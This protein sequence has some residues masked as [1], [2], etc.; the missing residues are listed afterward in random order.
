VGWQGYSSYK[1]WRT[2]QMNIPK[3]NFKSGLYF[4]VLAIIAIIVINI[5]TISIPFLIP[6]GLVIF[7]ILG[8]ILLIAGAIWA[9]GLIINIFK[10][11]VYK[12]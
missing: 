5:I 4:V 11:I 7:Q 9:I 12:V 10:K 8:T 3:G 6:I 2:K 1:L